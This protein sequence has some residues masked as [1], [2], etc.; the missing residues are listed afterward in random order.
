[1]NYYVGVN[2]LHVL[3]FCFTYVVLAVVPFIF[4]F[5]VFVCTG[6]TEGGTR[7]NTYRNKGK[8]FYV[9]LF[10]LFLEHKIYA[11]WVQLFCIA[12]WHLSYRNI[13]LHLASKLEI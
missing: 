12:A 13:S 7:E 5:V 9:T 11:V 6:Y 2:H 10:C 4:N 1:M 3:C 8:Y